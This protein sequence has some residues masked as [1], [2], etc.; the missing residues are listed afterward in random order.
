MFVCLCRTMAC[1]PR[2]VQ[3]S[4]Q[5]PQSRPMIT[6]R[7]R[8]AARV[9]RRVRVER[10]QRKKKAPQ[11]GNITIN[12]FWQFKKQIIVCI[13]IYFEIQYWLKSNFSSTFSLFSIIQL[14]V[15]SSLTSVPLLISVTGTQ[16]LIQSTPWWFMKTRARGERESKLEAM[17]T[18]PC[19][20][21]GWVIWA[22][23]DA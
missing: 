16:T 18:R 4:S 23:N 22:H 19:W 8:R 9:V 7:L 5:G 2:S 12:E 6:P 10:E 20:C 3:R 11:I 13:C 1:L 14:R 17:G 21:R 15:M